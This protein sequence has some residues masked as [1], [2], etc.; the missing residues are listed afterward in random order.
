MHGNVPVF[1]ERYAYVH[2]L[3]VISQIFHSFSS[4]MEFAP[5]LLELNYAVQRLS[6]CQ[7]FRPFWP[8]EMGWSLHQRFAPLAMREKLAP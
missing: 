8:A 3:S 5:C 7:I 6:I 1:V 4:C 2:T